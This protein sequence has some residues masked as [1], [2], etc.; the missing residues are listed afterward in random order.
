MT[1]AIQNIFLTPFFAEDEY[2]YSFIAIENCLKKEESKY[3]LDYIASV[4]DVYFSFSDYEIQIDELRH[5][6]LLSNIKEE[7]LRQVLKQINF[8]KVGKYDL[9]VGGDY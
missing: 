3:I 1:L 9:L 8:K 2:Q 5:C 6:I 7:N 4:L